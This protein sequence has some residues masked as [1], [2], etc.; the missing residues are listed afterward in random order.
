[1]TAPSSVRERMAFTVGA[2]LFR[3]ALSFSTGMLIARWLGPETVG[4]MAFLLGT[5]LGIR[6][7]IDMGSSSAFFTFLSQRPRS[8]NFVRSFFLWLGLQ[9]LIPLLLVGLVFPSHWVETIWLG[10]QRGLV[11]LAFMAAFMQGSVWPVIQRAGESQRR[12][13]HVQG[14]GVIV[15]AVHLVAMTV[16]W[17][18]GALGLYAIFAAIAVEYLVAAFVAHRPFEHATDG[19]SETSNDDGAPTFRHFVQYCLPLVPY[20]WMSF[21]YVFVDRWMLQRFGGE[22]EQAY[23]AI[24]AQF[25]SIA[26]IATSSVLSV[27]WKEIAEA[28]HQGDDA[29][30]AMLYQKVSRLLFLVGA[31][32]A[33]FLIPWAE[34]LLR[35]LLGVAY[36]GG[37]TTLAIMFLYPVHQSMGQIAGTML[38][39]TER[40]PIQVITGIVFMA[41]SIAVTY[42]VLAPTDYVIPGLGMASEGL[43]IKMVALQ[44]IQVNVVTYIIARIWRWRFDWLF[45]PVSLVG[46]A[47]LGWLAHL[48]S[49]LVNSAAHPLVAI[50]LGGILYL[51]LLVPFVCSMPWLAGMTRKELLQEAR[52]V[53][54]NLGVTR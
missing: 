41:I 11:L 1:M 8:G 35:L 6:Q 26:L 10:E 52:R 54:R 24:G 3:S 4:R 51:A 19:S 20:A 44:L 5:F 38:Y 45:Q 21:A 40:V 50:G 12:T 34:D 15:V 28:H 22:V 42:V 47:A 43:A 30:T 37:A 32:I 9:F 25:S 49:A 46:C 7:L 13:R 17:W 39:A 27:F 29:R 2:N 31:V 18:L 53:A 48:A 16:L 14:L 23:Y 33:G 36:V